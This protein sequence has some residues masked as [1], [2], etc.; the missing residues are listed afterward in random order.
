MLPGITIHFREKEKEK[1]RE[2]KKEE[3]DASLER[4]VCR[5]EPR[6]GYELKLKFYSFLG[7]ELESKSGTI[8][9]SLAEIWFQFGCETIHGGAFNAINELLELVKF[10]AEF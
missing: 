5:Q 8:W 4:R 3:I 6:E 9:K 1:E 2:K 7:N 10:E